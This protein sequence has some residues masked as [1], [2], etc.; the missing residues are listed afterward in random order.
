MIVLSCTNTLPMVLCV[1]NLG[2]VIAANVRAE[3]AR[4]HWRQADL[5]ERLGW[6]TGTVGHLETGR[7]DVRAADLPALCR[8]FG[9]TLD[10]LLQDADPEDRAALG[11]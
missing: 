9:I 7:R 6:D 11:L 10:R 8:A 3:R 2:H 4:R 5:A 1:A